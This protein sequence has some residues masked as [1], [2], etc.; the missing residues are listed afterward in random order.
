[1][2][3]VTSLIYH[4]FSCERC[5]GAHSASL[6]EDKHE[7][8]NAQAMLSIEPQPVINGEDCGDALALKCLGWHV[9]RAKLAQ[10]NYSSYALSYEKCSEHFLNF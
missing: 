1:M 3:D 2:A 10:K 8:G 9:P 4:C 5:D 6:I 7:E